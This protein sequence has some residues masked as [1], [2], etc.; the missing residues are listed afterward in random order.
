MSETMTPRAVRYRVSHGMGGRL[1]AEFLLTELERT[2]AELAR[3]AHELERL[4]EQWRLNL[5]VGGPVKTDG[6]SE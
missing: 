5:S 4:V 1:E 2:E 3:V 6:G